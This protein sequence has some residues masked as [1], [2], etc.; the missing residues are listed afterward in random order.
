MVL[1][2]PMLALVT[3]MPPNDSAAAVGKMLMKTWMSINTQTNGLNHFLNSPCA[4]T[5][6]GTCSF[7]KAN[8]PISA[9]CIAK[10]DAF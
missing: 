2:M 5:P 9:W 6:A 8:S 7:A 10:G 3:Y 4:L 1:I